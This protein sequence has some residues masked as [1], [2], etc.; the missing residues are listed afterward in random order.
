MK[1]AIYCII[2]LMLFLSNCTKKNDVK[3]EY[4]KETKEISHEPN[5]SFS[6]QYDYKYTVMYVNTG[7]DNLNVR[8]I[9][10]IDGDKINSLKPLTEVLIIDEDVNIININGIV[11]KWVLVQILAASDGWTQILTPIKGWV[12][13][14][15]LEKKK[16]NIFANGD[17]MEDI[18]A[19]DW[20]ILDADNYEKENTIF[21]M[22]FCLVK[23]EYG[24]RWVYGNYGTE[25]MKLGTSWEMVDDETI[26]L[27]YD[28]EEVD[29]TDYLNNIKFIDNDMISCSLFNR[30]EI[31][32]KLKRY[33]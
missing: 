18:M 7:A 10:S 25:A 9:P 22:V 5:L 29:S 27:E 19:G 32:K 11:G 14:G 2:F 13:S 24:K 23:D 30:F 20:R 3:N 16:I 12:F 4:E 28:T 6:S 15:Y 1:N 33:Y 17:N 31:M 21:F 26:K 8:N